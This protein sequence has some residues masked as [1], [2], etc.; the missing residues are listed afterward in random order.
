MCTLNLLG[1]KH[2]PFSKYACEDWTVFLT[3]YQAAPLDL[4]VGYFY[5]T[6]SHERKVNRKEKENH[7]TVAVRSFYERR[8]AIMETYFQE[9]IC[10]KEQDI[11]QIIHEI[12]QERIVA[13][14][15]NKGADISLSRDLDEL[16]TLS[17][18]ACGLGG[19]RLAAI[20]R[21]LAFDY[22]HYSGG[23]PD[24]LLAKVTFVTSNAISKED[25]HGNGK[26]LVP[27]NAWVGEAFQ[28][29]DLHLG[30]VSDLSKLLV[31][32]DDEFLGCEKSSDAPKLTRPSQGRYN[33]NKMNQL[34]NSRKD[35]QTQEEDNNVAF[36]NAFHLAKPLTMTF[37]N[38][39]VS[40]HCMFVEVSSPCFFSL[41]SV[42]FCTIYCH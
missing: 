28:N 6:I 12:I 13:F 31:D 4:H 9:L 23:L 26:N 5:T 1:F 3:P 19:Q 39:K 29:F 38:K 14:E 20:F 7:I 18:I 2:D 41:S 40:V 42:S 34:G 33:S 10:M 25:A 8:R 22:R 37:Q 15:E 21:C 11:C 24:L 36:Q 17:M 27:L 16:R 35:N 32:R 30:R